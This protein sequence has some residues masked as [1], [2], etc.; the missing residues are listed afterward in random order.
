MLEWV[1]VASARIAA[2]NEFVLARHDDNWV[3]RVDGRMLMSSKMH[4]SEIALAEL[5]LDAV[6]DA[7]AV[8]VGGLGLGY[9][10]RAVLDGGG[11]NTRVT[12]A[13]LVPELV[14]WNRTHLA[15]LNDRALEDPRVEV[16]L[17]DVHETLRRSRGRFDA[18]LLDVDNG[19]MALSQARNQRLYNESG[20]RF[21]FDALRPGGVLTVW[22]VGHQSKYE[23]KLRAAGFDVE[24][25]AVS[26]RTGSRAKHV[27][28]VA[29]R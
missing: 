26:A 6:P 17:G 8:L 4:Q 14:E 15:P 12:V 11:P 16:A 13:E 24:A 22:S 28:F 10:L 27:V 5:A 19:P 2:G 21:C 9:T 18:I 29:T 1:T 3:V 20:I 25:K 23:K 7:E